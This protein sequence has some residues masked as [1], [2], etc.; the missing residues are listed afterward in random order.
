M[1]FLLLQK[2]IPTPKV[3]VPFLWSDS[4]GVLSHVR[5]LPG[6]TGLVSMHHYKKA[7]SSNIRVQGLPYGGNLLSPSKRT[8]VAEI[9]CIKSSDSAISTKSNGEID[10]LFDLPFP[11]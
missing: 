3:I 9:S 2:R 6:K 8:R 7:T 5:S 1:I 11:S 4:F 10:F